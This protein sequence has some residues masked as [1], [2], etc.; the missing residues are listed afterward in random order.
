MSPTS[1]FVALVGSLVALAPVAVAAQDTDALRPVQVGLHAG[2]SM[3]TGSFRSSVN[4]GIAVGAAI[5]LSL[6]GWWSGRADLDFH[7]FENHVLSL[8]NTTSGG[9]TSLSSAT[10]SA[11]L[12]VRNRRHDIVPYALGGLGL[13]RFGGAESAVGSQGSQLGL[14][15][16]FGLDCRLQRI[17]AFV[18]VR[19]HNVPPVHVV[20]L[21]IGFR[22]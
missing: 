19:Y 17:I 3:P 11:V 21:T 14:H 6:S 20:P 5:E 22:Y 9:T 12:R 1:K 7:R 16:G 10:I 8:G 4:N 2:A 13:Y 15:G 18:E